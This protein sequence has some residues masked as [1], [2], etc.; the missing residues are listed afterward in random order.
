MEFM[1]WLGENS[2]SFSIVFTKVDK[3]KPSVIDAKIKAYSKAMLDG[4]W[5]EMPPYFTTSSTKKTGRE[6]LLAYLNQINQD[7]FKALKNNR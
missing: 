4:S 2:I 7:F 6:A 3:L 1:Q 5:A